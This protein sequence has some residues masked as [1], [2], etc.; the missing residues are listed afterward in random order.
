MSQ[1]VVPSQNFTLKRSRFQFTLGFLIDRFGI[2]HL[3]SHCHRPATVKLVLFLSRLFTSLVVIG[4]I[5]SY[6]RNVWCFINILNNVGSLKRL[7][8]LA[9][10][11]IVKDNHITD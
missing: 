7:K 6:A 3:Y 2:Q 11:T 4:H 5:G 1:N 10:D 9:K 8:E